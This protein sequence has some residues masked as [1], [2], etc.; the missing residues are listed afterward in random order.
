MSNF[1]ICNLNDDKK[2]NL[3]TTATQH[4]T[5]TPR[6]GSIFLLCDP[7][8]LRHCGRIGFLVLV[9]LRLDCIIHIKAR[10]AST[11]LTQECHEYFPSKGHV[12]KWVPSTR[13]D[14][15]YE[16]EQNQENVLSRHCNSKYYYKHGQIK[17]CG[18]ASGD[19]PHL[20]A[21]RSWS[22]KKAGGAQRWCKREGTAVQCNKL[23]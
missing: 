19:C 17:S 7:H 9:V 14:F 3:L 4:P 20:R 8:P 6:K 10:H 12:G 5:H 1:N 15:N 16:Q 18:P 21:L 23:S 22:Q 2:L 13:H 11:S